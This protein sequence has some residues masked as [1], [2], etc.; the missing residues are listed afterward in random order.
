MRKLNKTLK[1]NSF[2]NKKKQKR[3][4]SYLGGGEFTN[5]KNLTNAQTEMPSTSKFDDA[6][7][8]LNE[9]YTLNRNHLIDELINKLTTSKQLVDEVSTKIEDL[10]YQ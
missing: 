9:E 4:R 7:H 6:L 3:S 8:W 1:K 2:R 5:N 10:I